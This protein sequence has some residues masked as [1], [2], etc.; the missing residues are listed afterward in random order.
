MAAIA[1]LSESVA[2]GM[3]A[4][5]SALRHDLVRQ[6]VT[7]GADQERQDFGAGTNKYVV[8]AP[9]SVERL[10]GARARA[11]SWRPGARAPRPA[12]GE[13]RTPRPSTRAP[14]SG[15]TGRP[16]PDRA[17]PTTLRTPG[18]SAAPLRRSRDRGRRAGTRTAAPTGAGAHRSSYTASAR[19]PELRPEA[20]ARSDG[21]TSTP[22]RPLPAATYRSMAI[23]PLASAERSKSSPSATNSPARS[24]Q[25][26]RWRSLRISLSFWLCG[27]VIIKKGAL[28]KE[29]RPGGGA[30]SGRLL[31]SRPPAPRGR[32]RQTVGRCRRRGRR[33]PR[34]SCGRAR[35]RRAGDR[36]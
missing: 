17:P 25:R 5:W 3:C 23:Q 9:K 22:E 6:A 18:P 2:I 8:G 26:R 19:V 31:V 12:R 4:T 16:C 1:A 10:A 33:C 30:G 20:L 24:R 11:R 29:R 36:A 32:G 15:C 13:P 7:F 35:R 28:L 34:G 27:L 21:S 14:P